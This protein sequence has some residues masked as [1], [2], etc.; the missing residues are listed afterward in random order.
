MV[1]IIQFA[2]PVGKGNFVW[3][4]NPTYIIGKIIVYLN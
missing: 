2:L 4:E 3:I 1:K